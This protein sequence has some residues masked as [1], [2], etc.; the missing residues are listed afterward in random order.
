MQSLLLNLLHHMSKIMRDRDSSAT[1]SQPLSSAV[2]DGLLQLLQ[3]QRPSTRLAAAKIFNAVLDVDGALR[4]FDGETASPAALEALK[5]IFRRRR[6]SADKPTSTA[7]T[8]TMMTMMKTTMTTVT[9][10]IMTLPTPLTTTTPQSAMATTTMPTIVTTTTPKMMSTT[11]PMPMTTM[12]M[13]TITMTTMPTTTMP[14]TTMTMTTMAMMTIPTPTMTTTPTMTKTTTMPTR[15]AEMSYSPLSKS[16]LG[17]IVATLK[18][19]AVLPDNSPENVASIFKAF[20]LLALSVPGS[21]PPIVAACLRIQVR[22][23]VY[24]GC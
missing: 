21:S 19:S 24:G 20:L 11:T 3:S 7:T 4:D 18:W 8:A 5:S 1:I 17:E 23:V 13:T 6:T 16:P 12:P 15:E 14:M 9:T 22:R 2:V 10:T